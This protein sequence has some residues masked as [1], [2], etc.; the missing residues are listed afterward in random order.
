MNVRPAAAVFL[1]FL[2]SKPGP[3]WRLTIQQNHECVQVDSGDVEDVVV[4]NDAGDGEE[5]QEHESVPVATIEIPGKTER[6]NVELVA[7]LQNNYAW[8]Q[9][10]APEKVQHTHNLFQ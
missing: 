3:V 6:K 7:Y 5:E 9:I 4:G 10:S 1:T 8:L 2:A